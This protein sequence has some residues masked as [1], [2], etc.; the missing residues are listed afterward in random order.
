MSR[1]YI[2]TTGCVR[3]CTGIL[4]TGMDFVPN[5]PNCAVLILTSYRSYRSVRYRCWRCTELTEASGIGTTVCTG[6]AV[7]GFDF[8]PNSPKFSVPVL[9]SYQPYRSLRYNYC[10]RT[11]LT[12]A[13]CTGIDVVPD[14]LKRPVLVRKSVPVLVRKSVPVPVPAH[15]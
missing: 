11:E 8:I 6:A 9:M 14:L 10:R 5:L 15:T 4:G 12:E 13:S 3:Y 1:E 7:N 2:A